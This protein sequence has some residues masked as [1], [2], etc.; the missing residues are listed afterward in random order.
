MDK[1]DNVHFGD[2][3]EELEQILLEAMCDDEDYWEELDRLET[4]HGV[5]GEHVP[6]PGL[7]EE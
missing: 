1:N 7:G 2:I 3:D 6:A 4:E 5:S